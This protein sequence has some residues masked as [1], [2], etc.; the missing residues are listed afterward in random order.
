MD[1]GFVGKLKDKAKG[2]V[3]GAKDKAATAALMSSVSSFNPFGKKKG[4][5]AMPSLGSLQS[6]TGTKDAVPGKKDSVVTLAIKILIFVI[7]TLFISLFAAFTIKKTKDFTTDNIMKML[8]V[9]VI[10]NVALFFAYSSKISMLDFLI[11]SQINILCFYMILTYTTLTTLFSNGIFEALKS[12]FNFIK[13]ITTDP[14]SIFENGGQLFIPIFFFIIPTIVL[15][16]NFTQGIMQFL[17]VLVITLATGAII[18]FP[19]FY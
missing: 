15:L 1:A 18:L 8:F 4:K 2:S 16:Y 11:S 13:T 6:M 17:I 14:T 3:K 12:C 9:L 10:F 5:S 7:A 19:R